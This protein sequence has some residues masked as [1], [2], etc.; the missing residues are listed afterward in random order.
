MSIGLTDRMVKASG[1]LARG[2]MATAARVCQGKT[3]PG[4]SLTAQIRLGLEE[5]G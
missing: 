5:S 4:S 1:F 3:M 2:D